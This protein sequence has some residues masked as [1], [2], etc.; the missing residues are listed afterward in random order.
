MCVCV[1]AVNVCVSLCGDGEKGWNEGGAGIVC[2]LQCDK[3]G[4]KWN[5][6]FKKERIGFRRN[7]A[8]WVRE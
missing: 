6:R 8:L 3:M 2:A 5:S 7:A 1:E 4:V